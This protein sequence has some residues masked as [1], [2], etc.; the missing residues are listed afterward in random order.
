MTPVQEHTIL[1]SPTTRNLTIITTHCTSHVFL[2]FYAGVVFLGTITKSMHLSAEVTLERM[3][4][5]HAVVP[6]SDF[7]LDLLGLTVAIPLFL[8]SRILITRRFIGVIILLFFSAAVLAI[9]IRAIFK[10]RIFVAL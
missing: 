2:I 4:N 6:G 8:N 7:C 5:L 10:G 3:R 1:N 9:R